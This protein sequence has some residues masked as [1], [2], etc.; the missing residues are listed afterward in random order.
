MIRVSSTYEACAEL[1]ADYPL[2]VRVVDCSGTVRS[3]VLMLPEGDDAQFFVLTH[4]YGEGRPFFS[5]SSWDTGTNIAD[6]EADS[7]TVPDEVMSAVTRGIPIPRHGSLFG[8]RREDAIIALIAVY[9]QYTPGCTEPSWAVMPLAGSPEAQWPPFTGEHLFGSWFWKH[10]RTG[11]VVTLGDLIAGT[12][13]AVFWAD[14]EAVFGWDCCVVARDIAS[15][16][17]YTLRR[18]CYLYY[19]ALQTGTPVPALDELLSGYG[20]IDLAP[21][22]QRSGDPDC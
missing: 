22:L 21:R 4:E 7:G 20:K 1:F 5:L 3:M 15:H 17:G 19:K 18:G 10:Y 11:G 9:A 2:A 8:W 6:I 14:T 12:P 16:E 13:D